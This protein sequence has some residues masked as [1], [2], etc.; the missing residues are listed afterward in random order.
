MKKIILLIT[1]S[2]SFSALAQKAKLLV[3][4]EFIDTTSVEKNFDI[5]KGSTLKSFLPPKDKRDR[6][7]ENVPESKTWDE[8]QKDA[9]YMDIKNKNMPE[10]LKKYPKFSEEQITSLRGQL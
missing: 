5:E 10:I 6:L 4:D 1:F 3:V 2:L 8:Y 7:L 9:F